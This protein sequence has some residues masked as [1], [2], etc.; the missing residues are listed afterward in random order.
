MVLHNLSKEQVEI[1]N[2]M[3]KEGIILYDDSLESKEGNTWKEDSILLA[4]HSTMVVK[5]LP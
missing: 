5:I 3:L 2:E 4:P 1:Q